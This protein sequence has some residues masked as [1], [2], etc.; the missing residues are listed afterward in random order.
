MI[1][2]SELQSDFFLSKMDDKMFS[3][4]KPLRSDVTGDDGQVF[5]MENGKKFLIKAIEEKNITAIGATDPNS[6]WTFIHDPHI[7]KDLEGNPKLIVGNSSDVKGDFRLVFI[8]IDDL[9]YFPIMGV[10]RELPSVPKAPE[11]LTED[12]LLGT[13]FQGKQDIF[14]CLLPTWIPFYNGQKLPEGDARDESNKEIISTCGEGYQTW[15]DWNLKMWGAFNDVT[16]TIVEEIEAHNDV[17]KYIQPETSKL[18]IAKNGP[19]SFPYQVSAAKYPDIAKSIKKFFIPDLPSNKFNAP[20]ANTVIRVTSAADE[21]KEI[22]AKHGES[23]CALYFA[24]GKF[25]FFTP[26]V[27]DLGYVIW[28]KGMKVVLEKPLTARGDQMSSLL[29]LGH[30]EAKKGSRTSLFAKYASIKV[31][32][33]STATSLLN[34]NLEREP[35][36]SLYGQSNSFDSTQYLPQKNQNRANRV[37]EGDLILKSQSM[38]NVHASNQS[39]PKTAMDRLGSIDNIEDFYR[40]LINCQNNTVSVIDRE[41]MKKKGTPNLLDG[42]CEFFIELTGGDFDDW[43]TRTGGGSWIHYTLFQYWDSMHTKLVQFATNYVNTNLFDTGSSPSELEID[44]LISAAKVGKH[45]NDHF[46]PLIALKQH[47]PFRPSLAPEPIANEF[48]ALPVSPSKEKGKRNYTQ[49]EGESKQHDDPSAG[50]HFKKRFG[51]RSARP[52]DEKPK[53]NNLNLGMFY[54]KDPNNANPFLRDSK[55]CPDFTCKGRECFKGRDCNLVHIAK[56][57][58]MAQISAIGEMFMSNKS[59]WFNH[60]VFRKTDLESKYKKLLGNESGIFST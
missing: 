21:E 6:Q 53:R 54:L 34:G 50:Q 51:R 60:V 14:I 44:S 29:Q 31:V 27:T 30:D 15:Q 4:S 25:N 47:D 38:M 49:R 56:P 20:G 22:A 57:T 2:T 32:S 48:R 59:G 36:G 5:A 8:K 35:V 18:R 23:K 42:I 52:E 45:A 43:I 40:L 39:A 9:A 3:R 1:L 28:S 13:T 58:D 16:L 33:K 46:A 37:K 17:S 11:A 12:H 55:L 10:K 41:E 7:H 19:A 26:D 24:G